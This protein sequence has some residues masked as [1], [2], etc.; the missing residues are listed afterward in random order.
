MKHLGIWLSFAVIV[1][2][3]F[4]IMARAED[5]VWHTPGQT[6]IEERPA[7][8][9]WFYAEVE[10]HILN[11]TNEVRIENG[12]KRVAGEEVLREISRMHSADMMER[13]FFSH[14][15][16]DG[17]SPFDRIA[18]THRTLIGTSGEN[19]Y[20]IEG[21]DINNAEE[22]AGMFM[23]GWMNS[24][25]HRANILS[26]DYTHLGVGA[27]VRDAKVTATQ[28][29][30]K[31]YAYTDNP[32]PVKVKRNDIINMKITPDSPTA[33][34]PDRVDFV[35]VKSGKKIAGPFNLPDVKAQVKPGAY[36]LRFYFPVDEYNWTI[37]GG[38]RI[39]VVK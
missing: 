19:I 33:I 34:A 2:L 37:V 30:A 23:T 8:E 7:G 14:D 36:N 16:P 4:C 32:L 24:P 12:L 27:A 3:A 35:K 1:I 15:N 21:Y 26:K 5:D 18:I 11:M 10:D 6:I 28:N 9:I 13:D 22:I 25:P 17:L 29:F 39:E 31:V 20:Y 38:P